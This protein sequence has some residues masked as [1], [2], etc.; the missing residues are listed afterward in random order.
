MDSDS[1]VKDILYQKLSE[2]SE[3]TIQ[4]E[5]SKNNSSK[6][7]SELISKCLPR[8]KQIS[9]NLDED[10]GIFAESLLHYFLT[11]AVIPSQRKVSKN[12]VE[13]DISIPDLKTLDSNPK[14]VLIIIFPKSS[15]KNLIQK[16]ISDITQ[17]QPINE[18]IWL[19]LHRNFEAKNKIYQ[20]NNNSLIKI[21]DD[22]KE[23][24]S[25]RKQNKFKI[26]KS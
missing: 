2:I 11:L 18:N 6:I 26:M 13:I 3:N 8:I 14:D 7:I 20:I 10:Y 12:G 17:I 22:I 21:L 9:H 19:V 25:T 5:I 16:R 23:F 1:P 24:L 4:L 15:D